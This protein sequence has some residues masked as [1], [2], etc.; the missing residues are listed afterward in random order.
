MSIKKILTL[1]FLFSFL[2]VTTNLQALEFIQIRVQ[3]NN[4][5][6]KITWFT[7]F[8]TT[9]YFSIEGVT[10]SKTITKHDYFHVMNISGLETNKKYIFIIEAVDEDRSIV[11]YSNYFYTRKLK[12]NKKKIPINLNKFI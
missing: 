7:T 2:L 8:H 4:T 11:S 3:V 10:A 5:T 12:L 9:C 6:A 1:F